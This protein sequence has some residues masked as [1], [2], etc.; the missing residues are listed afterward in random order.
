MLNCSAKFFKLF[1]FGEFEASFTKV[2]FDGHSLR[3][4][5]RKSQRTDLEPRSFEAPKFKVPLQSLDTLWKCFKRHIQP[6][7]QTPWAR[8]PKVENL[9][10]KQF[11][12]SAFA[13]KTFADSHRLPYTKA[14]PEM[15]TNDCFQWL[16]MQSNASRNFWLSSEVCSKKLLKE[17]P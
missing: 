12:F 6:Q 11:H 5:G 10:W 4:L 17:V 14:F 3:S 9:Q 8:Y 16:M 13:C 7:I 1:L 2:P 15:L